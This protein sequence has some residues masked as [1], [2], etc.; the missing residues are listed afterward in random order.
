LHE[1]GLITVGVQRNG[2]DLILVVKDNGPGLDDITGNP[3]KN[4]LGIRLSKERIA[5][6]NEIYKEKTATLTIHAAGTGTEVT[7]QLNNW[8]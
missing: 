6:L 5:L 7:I 4:S 3:G 8:L 1:K 2:K